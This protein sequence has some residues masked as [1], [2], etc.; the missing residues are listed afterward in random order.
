MKKILSIV[1]VMILVTAF[2]LAPV[3]ATST[4]I[5]KVYSAYYASGTLYAFVDGVGGVEPGSLTV[6]P[7]TDTAGMN[8]DTPKPITDTDTKIE[9][10]LLIDAS[11]S[12]QY[13]LDSVYNFVSSLMNTE[14]Q[15]VTVSVASFGEEDAYEMIA[16]NLTSTD[17]VMEIVYNISYTEPYTNICGSV[18]RAIDDIHADNRSGSDVINLV[19]I[20][21]GQ[22]DLRDQSPTAKQTIAESA[23][24]VIT[25]CP[26]IILHTI[27][28][29]GNWESSAY[30]ALSLGSGIHQNVN[31]PSDA[32]TAGADMANLIDSLYT[33]KL[34]LNWESERSRADVELRVQKTDDSKN[35]LEF[36]TVENVADLENIAGSPDDIPFIEYSTQPQIPD[37]SGIVPEDSS[38]SAQDETAAALTEATADQPN[39]IFTSG[40]FKWI[41]IA[42]G[43]VIIAAAAVV[44]II[45][46]LRKRKKSSPP[47]TSDPASTA[48]PAQTSPY[49]GYSAD[50]SYDSAPKAYAPAPKREPEGPCI[51]MQLQMIEG[52]SPSVSKP[53]KL[54]NEIFIGS[55]PDCDIILNDPTVASRN[56]RIFVDNSII[57]IE[58][59]STSQNVYLEGM[60]LFSRNRLRSQSEITVGNTTFTLLF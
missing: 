24:D 11:G 3:S 56:A 9:Y 19:V 55:A 58:N 40:L 57:Y 27:C 25:T 8:S 43:A 20:T 6:K 31:S 45:V 59:I 54:F 13:Y 29:G 16:Q 22:P 41:L 10:V 36:F 23:K 46:V 14:E 21:D 37:S 12:I 17:K 32:T 1:L 50:T 60:K 49:V 51:T 28:F 33:F 44:I 2:A 38:D 42:V 18:I 26:E 34:P 53:I 52:T 47:P 7:K 30:D 15:D 5:M 35:S 48:D 4:Q 39:G